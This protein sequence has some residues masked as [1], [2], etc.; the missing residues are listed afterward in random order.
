MTDYKD[1]KWLK[2]RQSILRRDNYLCRECKRYGKTTPAESVHHIIP[3][4]ISIELM[5]DNNNLISLCNSC[6]NAMH[7]RETRSLTVKGMRWVTWLLK[8]WS[9]NPKYQ[10][11]WGESGAEHAQPPLF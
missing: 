10:A 7:Y 5:Y 6:H 1:K 4:E 2:K 3:V 9:G 8:K 11:I